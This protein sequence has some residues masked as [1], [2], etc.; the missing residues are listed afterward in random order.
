MTSRE[1]HAAIPSYVQLCK[2]GES[3][4]RIER[5]QTLLDPC[6]LCS[7]ACGAR[8]LQGEKGRCS[9]TDRPR[10]T[11]FFPH[12][13]EENCLRGFGGSGT[14]F[15]S[16]CNLGC[17]F[18]QNAD[19]SQQESGV[20]VSDGQLADMM[21]Q[22]QEAGCHNINFVTP[23][24]VVPHL[25]RALAQAVERGLRLPLVYNT[26]AYDSLPCLEL[27]DGVVDIYMPDFKYWDPERARRYLQAPDYPQVA[28]EVIREMHRQVG[29]LVLD[30]NGIARR[31]LLVRHL[32]MPGALDDTREILTFLAQDISSH[33]YVN[34][35]DQYRP[36]NRVGLN[37]YPELNRPVRTQEMQDVWRLARQAGLYHFARP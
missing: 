1:S 22:L 28:R 6:R 32:V 4:R 30:S 35:M 20:E 34:L 17:V 31:G 25:L 13:G 29:D 23:S 3:L 19:I 26:S 15:F 21:L 9:T 7:R 2:S 10:V 18:C 33:T 12:F 16:G 27:L 11:S 24:H 8:R 5:I 37:S 14:I 36:A